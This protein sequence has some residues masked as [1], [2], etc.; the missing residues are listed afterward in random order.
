MKREEEKTPCLPRFPSVLVI[1][2][3]GSVIPGSVLRGNA[4]GVRVHKVCVARALSHRV[5]AHEVPALLHDPLQR[6]G[7]HGLPDVLH[8][9]TLL[10]DVHLDVPGGGQAVR[11]R[12]L[13]AVGQAVVPGVL[14]GLGHLLVNDALLLLRLERPHVV[15]SMKNHVHVILHQQLVDGLGPPRAHDIELPGPDLPWCVLVP[16]VAAPLE[17]GDVVRTAP[18]HGEVVDENKLVVCIARFQGFRQPG[19]L[20]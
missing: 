17:E 8:P 4:A 2:V 15:V 6:L 13:V 14:V 3:A 7:V 16:G 1:L 10:R 18:R 5:A 11:V 20:G 12:A 9:E 19:V